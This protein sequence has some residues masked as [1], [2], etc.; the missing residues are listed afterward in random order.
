MIALLQAYRLGRFRF[1]QLF[2]DALAG[3]LVALIA[4]PLAMAF[5]IASGMT[6]QQGLF[7]AIVAGLV[8]A[9]FGG[10]LYQVTGP[11]GAFIVILSG[12]VAQHG[13]EGLQKATLMGGIM[14][15]IMGVF[16][17][18]RWIEHIPESVT[19]AF[20]CGIALI[21]WLGQWPDFFGI[22]TPTAGH[23]LPKTQQL[24]SSLPHYDPHTA[25]LSCLALGLLWVLP[26]IHRL[27]P[28]A[29]ITLGCLTAL[30]QYLGWE[31]VRTIGSTFG[32]LPNHMPSFHWLPVSWQEA[33]TLFPAACS[34]ALLGAIESL[35][36][37]VVA[38]RLSQQR[39]KHEPKHHSNQELIGQ[40]LAN[41]AAPLWG[42][43]AATGAIARTAANL[44]SGAQSPLASMFHAVVLMLIVKFLAHWSSEIPLCALAAILFMVCYHMGEWGRF[45][46]CLAHP[47]HRVIAIA[48]FLA[49]VLTNLIAGVAVGLA[50]HWALE[51]YHRRQ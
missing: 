18:G 23:F 33:R 21:I 34:I 17:L 29:L 39:D 14:L 27:M 40:G 13:P 22:P 48:T 28:A 6:P 8:A 41:I 44:R 36:S 35:L 49:T 12:I 10:S 15:L 46:H 2:H 7:T 47:T 26:K 1:P 43:F 31:S 38:D 11:T 5:A 32:A 25:I 9:A 16:R 37:A 30:N 4:L 50:V 51:P 42:G 20:T 3:T 45:K 24:V 19:V